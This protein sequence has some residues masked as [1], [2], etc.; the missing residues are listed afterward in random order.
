VA[1]PAVLALQDVALHTKRSRLAAATM[2]VV[3]LTA[4]GLRRLSAMRSA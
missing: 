2:P 3:E 4:L 1:P